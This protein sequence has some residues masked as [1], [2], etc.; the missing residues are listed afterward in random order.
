MSPA[1]RIAAWALGIAAL[2]S[3]FQLGRVAQ[4]G[5]AA[6]AAT[7]E[8][9][10]TDGDTGLSLEE[11]ASACEEDCAELTWIEL[12]GGVFQM[13]D[14]ANEGERPAHTVALPGFALTRSEVTVAQYRRC[15]QA[16]ACAEPRG[17]GEA[18]NYGQPD[19]DDH[20]V[21][22]VSWVAA[23]RFC[24]WAGAR[25][26][27][28][29]EWEYAARGAGLQHPHPWGEEEPDCERAVVMGEDLGCGLGGTVPVCSKPAGHS[30]QG[31][32]DM[33]GNVWEWVQDYHRT[34]YRQAP[35]DG[36]AQEQAGSGFKVLRGGA[37]DT[38][39]E[40]LGNSKRRAR[41]PVHAKR[42]T[43]FR[44]AR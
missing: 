11:P 40:D 30:E 27:S 3:A 23:D 15:V 5:V 42:R 43:G 1:A 4:R 39:P 28:E 20:P 32:C 6:P 25:L 18:S 24:R 41:P 33:A 16:G 36:G 12:P 26:P 29:S 10:A 37:L 13:G 2:A 19:R 34:D 22:Y 8:A 7:A 38:R 17:Q 14:D 31:L 21:N 9:P 44:C 35:L